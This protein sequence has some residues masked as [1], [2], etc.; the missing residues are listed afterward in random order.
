MRVAAAAVVPGLV[1]AAAAAGLQVSADRPGQ[2]GRAESAQA[3]R[4]GP[5]SVAAAA[6]GL[7]ASA[8]VVVPVWAAV[9]QVLCVLS[10][11]SEAAP[12]LH[13]QEPFAEV[14]QAE[15]VVQAGV[16]PVQAAQAW[17][18]PA[19]EGSVLLVGWASGPAAQAA[20][21][22]QASARGP[23]QAGRAG[24]AAAAAAE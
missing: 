4:A 5:A 7:Q 6:P 17:D 2:A 3:A 18:H 24:S 13:P 8:A 19:A 11:P 16:R 20:R 9:A 12:R 23:V 15:R 21:A 10:A 22:V 14:V 1:V